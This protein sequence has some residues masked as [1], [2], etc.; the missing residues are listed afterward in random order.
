MLGQGVVLGAVGS[1][2]CLSF[3]FLKSWCFLTHAAML[4]LFLDIFP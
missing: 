4:V 2:P 3:A 1:S